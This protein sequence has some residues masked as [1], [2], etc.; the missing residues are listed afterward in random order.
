MKEG[1]LPE[2]PA[3]S[4]V[5]KAKDNPHKTLQELPIP[6]ALR[7][8]LDADGWSVIWHQHHTST[9]D[10]KDK[11]ETLTVAFERYG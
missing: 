6:E 11:V 7:K 10:S 1:R 3:L 4:L 2:K 9:T 5:G 8:L